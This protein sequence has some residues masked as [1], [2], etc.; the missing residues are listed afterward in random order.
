MEK[1]GR[2]FLVCTIEG[3]EWNWYA[4]F[5][6]LEEANDHL[7]QDVLKREHIQDN[8]EYGFII[9]SPNFISTCT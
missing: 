9:E 8:L 1:C 3:G 4:A 7:E 5:P 6:T 2:Q